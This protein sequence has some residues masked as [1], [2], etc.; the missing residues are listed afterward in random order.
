MHYIVATDHEHGR[1]VIHGVFD[2]ELN[3]RI[4]RENIRQGLGPN[5]KET[6]AYY[7]LIILV[8]QGNKK[9]KEIRDVEPE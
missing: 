7:S 8:Y 9:I 1:Y 2:C 5:A 6:R 3:A 4:A